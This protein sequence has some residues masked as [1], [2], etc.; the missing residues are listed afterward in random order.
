MD[1]N[2]TDKELI[3]IMGTFGSNIETSN[4]F[5]NCVVVKN[6]SLPDGWSKS[7]TNFMMVKDNNEFIPFLDGDI[8]SFPTNLGIFLVPYNKNWKRIMITNENYPNVEDI[9]SK[10]SSTLGYMID[11]YKNSNVEIGKSIGIIKNILIYQNDQC[12]NIMYEYTGPDTIVNGEIF[13]FSG[14]LVRNIGVFEIKEGNN[15]FE[16]NGKDDNINNVNKGVYILK[17]RY[18][19]SIGEIFKCEIINKNF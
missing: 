16:W 1:N 15:Q 5:P 2:F 17:L 8:N 7:V 12:L 9:I 14:S 6:L 10:L 19:Q 4:E 18:S 11:K 3:A 13:S